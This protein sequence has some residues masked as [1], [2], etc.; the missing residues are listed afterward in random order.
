MP[1]VL[2]VEFARKVRDLQEQNLVKHSTQIVLVSG[3]G[4]FIGNE[5]IESSGGM[6]FDGVLTKPFT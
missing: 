3:E 2:G 5:I 1:E 6:L 4:F